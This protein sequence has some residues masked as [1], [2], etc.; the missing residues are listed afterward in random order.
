MDP[1]EVRMQFLSLLRKLDATQ[2]SIQ[3]VVSYALRYF[4]RCG[5]DL[6]ECVVEECQKG[7]LNMRINLLYL[8]DNLCEASLTHQAQISSVSD[9]SSSNGQPAPVSYAQYVARDLGKIVQLVVPE[10]RGGLVNL[11]SARQILDSWRAKRIID[12]SRIDEIL[13]SLNEREQKLHVADVATTGQAKGEDFPREQV[14]RRFEEDRERHKL[15]RQKRWHVPVPAHELSALSPPPLLPKLSA[16]LSLRP[17]IY[18]PTPSPLQPSPQTSTMPPPPAP[19]SEPAP[20]SQQAG[21]VEIDAT[22]ESAEPLGEPIGIT[23]QTTQPPSDALASLPIPTSAEVQTAQPVKR[24]PPQLPPPETALDIEFD[25][26]WETTSDWNEDDEDAADEENFLCFGPPQRNQYPQEAEVDDGIPGLSEAAMAAAAAAQPPP[27]PLNSN[28]N[29]MNLNG[30]PPGFS[31]QTATGGSSPWD[32]GMMSGEG[33]PPYPAASPQT[34]NGSHHTSSHSH[35]SHSSLSGTTGL[36]SVPI[37]IP[38]PHRPAQG[39][40][41]NPNHALNISTSNRGTPGPPSAGA[42]GSY[43]PLPQSMSVPT[44]IGNGGSGSGPNTPG[45]TASGSYGSRPVGLPLTPTLP[46]TS[47]GSRPATPPRAATGGFYAGPLPPPQP[48]NAEIALPPGI[49]GQQQGRANSAGGG[50]SVTSSG[51]GGGGGGG[52]GWDREREW[53][54]EREPHRDHREHHQQYQHHNQH[55]QSYQQHHPSH[56][57]YNHQPRHSQ[58]Q[59]SGSYSGYSSYSSQTAGYYPQSSSPPPN[60]NSGSY[61][62]DSGMAQPPPPPQSGYS[63]SR[64]YGSEWN[65]GEGA[66]GYYSNGPGGQAGYPGSG[67]GW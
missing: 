57:S 5:D 21:G 3:K 20:E 16:T 35:L 47:T 46:G 33:T 1:F 9:P 52:G 34:I 64:G 60:L 67:G 42:R 49:A 50:G 56:Q 61:G 48:I 14:L 53:E 26:A 4:S 7:S 58:R 36:T 40:N 32:P 63:S 55:H 23:N 39:Y 38:L 12:P 11:M 30:L 54:R 10:A 2:L 8:L 31:D 27:A 24:L 6:W 43:P 51:S 41:P 65:Q 19:Q 59:H 29:S 15:L 17:P 45:S 44:G 62:Y 22:M 13:L 25:N 37:P 18:P 66:R 28:A